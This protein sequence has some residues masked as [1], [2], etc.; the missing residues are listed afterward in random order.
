[1][2]SACDKNR[3]YVKG[4]GQGQGHQNHENQFEP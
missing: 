1:M 2:P 3:T 4:Q